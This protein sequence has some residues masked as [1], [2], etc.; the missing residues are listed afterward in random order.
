MFAANL[1]CTK[2]A[3]QQAP[4]TGTLIVRKLTV[5][6]LI[7]VFW[8]TNISAAEPGSSQDDDIPILPEGAEEV[9]DA[10]QEE[11]SDI[12]EEAS[13]GIDSLF[14]EKP[15]GDDMPLLSNEQQE[16]LDAG[17]KIAS[18]IVTDAA[19]WFD[20]FFGDERFMAEENKTRARLKA[21]FGYSELDDFEVNLR[22]DWRIHLPKLSKR[23]NLIISAGEDDEF[24]SDNPI[25]DPNDKERTDFS[26]ALEYFVRTGKKFNFS[27]TIG[28]SYNY[29]YAGVRFRHFHDF[30]SWQGRLVDRLRYYTDDGWENR[31]SYDLE[32][33]ISERWLFR[34]T[35]NVNWY[36]DDDG[37]FYSLKF[38]LFQFLNQERAL[39]YEWENYFETEPD[40]IMTDLHLR[41]KYRQ[42]FYRDW[43]ILEIAPQVTFPEDND[44]DPNPGIVIQ[45]EADFGYQKDLN[46]FKRIF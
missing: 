21:S 20:N 12:V 7:A 45:F 25:S 19:T 1:S 27:T 2:S 6:L 22:I 13:E 11:I 37:I 34:T 43:L 38:R 28:A 32:R 17:Q 41:I 3:L 30:G 35:G 4:H 5:L 42:R 39:T 40:H 15:Q 23:A 14:G 36:E 9:L 29:V 31:L 8:T 18:A 26:A 10:G 16:T 24:T 33:R 46:V 44:R